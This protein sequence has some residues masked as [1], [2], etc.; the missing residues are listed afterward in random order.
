MNCPS[1]LVSTSLA[2][3]SA[4]R[5]ALALPMVSAAC[6]ASTS[7]DFSPWHRRSRISRRLG[8]DTAA[9]IRANCWERAPLN[10]RLAMVLS[11]TRICGRAAGHKSLGLFDLLGV[12]GEARFVVALAEGDGLAHP[13][14]NHQ[15]RCERQRRH[16][17][18]GRRQTECVGHNAGE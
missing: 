3:F 8:L 17:P 9:P 5:C 15:T 2:A 6:S 16:D 10:A 12:A 18:H 11:N 4:L 1:R 14:G 7:T 13:N